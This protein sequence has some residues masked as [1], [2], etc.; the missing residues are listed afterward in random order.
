MIRR[1]AAVMS[2]D[3]A[4]YSRLMND[5]EDATHA[6]FSAAMS[7]VVHP[8]LTRH[9]GRVVKSTG[10]GFLAEFASAVDAMRSSLDIQARITSEA[11]GHPAARRMLFRIGLNVGDVIVEDHDIYGHHVNL[12]ARLDQMAE[13]GDILVSGFVHEYVK[14]RVECGFHDLGELTLKNIGAPV[15]VWRVLTSGPALEGL[16]PADSAQPVLRLSLLGPTRMTFGDHELVFKSLKARALIAH[17]ALQEPPMETRE[18]IVGLLWS[19][20]NETQAR[21][22]LRQVVRE[23]R[24]RFEAAGFEGLHLGTREIGFAPNAVHVDILDVFDQLSRGAVHPLLLE[25]RDL[26][27][28]LLAGLEDLDPAFRSWLLPKRQTLRARLLRELEVVLAAAESGSAEAASAAQAIAN[29]DATHEP[30]CRALMR[31]RTLAGDEAGALRL[32]NALWTLLADDYDAEPSPETQA[33]VAE[34]KTGTL[35]RPAPAAAGT[36]TPAVAGTTRLALYVA[37]VS[38]HGLQGTETHLASG[39]RQQ[40]IGSLIRC[41]ELNVTDGVFDPAAAAGRI[42][43]ADCYELQLSVHQNGPALLLMPMLRACDTNVFVWSDGFELRL[44]SWV[45]SQR[46]TVKRVTMALNV[47]LSAER[48]RRVSGFADVSLKIH[49]R[50]LRSQTLI[51]TFNAQHWARASE[52]FNEIVATAPDFTPAYCGLADMLNAEHIAHPGR[53]RTR[54]RE[55]E[56]L[57]LARQAVQL[58]PADT[59]A[60]RSLAWAQAMAGRHGPAMTHM[61]TACELNACDS[62]THISAAL[63]LAFCGDTPAAADLA[64][65]ALDLTLAPTQSHWAYQVDIAFLSGDYDGALHAADQAQDLLSATPA[66]RAA[67]LGQLGRVGEAGEAAGL[68][69]DR[70]RGRWVGAE[71][72]S[73]EAIC[74]WMLHLYP[75]RM[76]DGWERLRGGLQA[77]GLPVASVAYGEW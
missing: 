24:E 38:F 72:A 25:R 64:R 53:M 71:A 32:Y 77:A 23:L 55:Q 21:A 52:Q 37:P 66:W 18:R 69:L 29:Q 59:R 68:F 35:P 41:R 27:D 61:R 1:L 54:E 13:P 11:A 15:R 16:R 17:I 60:H 12:A 70:I 46:R 4:G 36:A 73:D 6:Q 76:I 26:T 74:R 20:S 8:S 48:L 45:E 9:R 3:V 31:A 42:D 75:I 44:D 50:W 28:D 5:D 67:A 47:H 63:L 51:R 39:F 19:E 10:D 62:W 34:I 14:G 2:A 30:A 40:L 57:R 33:L 43:P 22:V 56:A 65:T 49:D 7:T 58:D